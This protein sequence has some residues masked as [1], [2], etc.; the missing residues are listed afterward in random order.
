[1]NDNRPMIKEYHFYI[2]DDHMHDTHYAQ[3]C[4][5]IIYGSLKTH[6]VVMYEHWIWSYGC[7]KQ[8]KYS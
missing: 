5:D 4:L 7:A 1:M 3:H 6:G 8:F 2:S